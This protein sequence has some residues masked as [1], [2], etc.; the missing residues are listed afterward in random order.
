[1]FNTEPL[2]SLLNITL[3]EIASGL[4]TRKFTAVDLTKAY[5]ARI[6]EVNHVFHAVLEINKDALSIAE[7]LDE[8]FETSGR[9]GFVD[10]ISRQNQANHLV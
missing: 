10:R 5:I 6:Q 1:M 7:A 4:D 9:R 3:D 2:P 8:E